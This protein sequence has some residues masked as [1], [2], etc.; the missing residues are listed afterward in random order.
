M[1]KKKETCNSV[2]KPK[3]LYRIFAEKYKLYITFCLVVC[4]K[5]TNLNK[6]YNKKL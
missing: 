5:I 3:I 6:A 2:V 4:I 1:T